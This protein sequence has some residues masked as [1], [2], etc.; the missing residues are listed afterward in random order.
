MNAIT[1][2]PAACAT[3][4]ASC[5]AVI[6]LTTWVET[7]GSGYVSPVDDEWEVP[8]TCLSYCH[9]LPDRPEIPMVPSVASGRRKASTKVMKSRDPEAGALETADIGLPSCVLH[10]Q[11]RSTVSRVLTYP[12][13]REIFARTRANDDAGEG[14]GE[15][16]MRSSSDNPSDFKSPVSLSPHEASQYSPTSATH[17]VILHLSDKVENQAGAFGSPTPSIHRPDR[18]PL[19]FPTKGSYSLFDERGRRA[20]SI[21]SRPSTIDEN[22]PVRK[23]YGAS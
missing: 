11:K 8:L 16:A 4:I 17:P 12:L 20:Q 22:Q 18:V 3:T 7:E 14:E 1:P 23:L 9:S 15:Q 21:E 6:W 5:R 13:C 19:L 2:I 10:Q